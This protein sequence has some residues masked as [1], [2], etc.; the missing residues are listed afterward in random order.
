MVVEYARIGVWRGRWHVAKHDPG[1]LVK[2]PQ[3]KRGD[4]PSARCVDG[5]HRQRMR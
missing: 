1:P 4:P 5:V 2:V 3:G